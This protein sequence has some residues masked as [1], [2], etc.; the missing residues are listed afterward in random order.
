MQ[1]NDVERYLKESSKSYK[2]AKV[3]NYARRSSL[4]KR[5]LGIETEKKIAAASFN[6]EEKHL[7]EQLKQMKIEKKKYSII[8]DLRDREH[9][10]SAVPEEPRVHE[11]RIPTEPYPITIRPLGSPK[12]ARKNG[13]SFEEEGMRYARNRGRRISKEFE[14]LHINTKTGQLNNKPMNMAKKVMKDKLSGGMTRS[15]TTL[16]PTSP[17]TPRKRSLSRKHSQNSDG[18]SPSHSVSSMDNIHW[19]GELEATKSIRR[20]RKTVEEQELITE[21]NRLSKH[22]PS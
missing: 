18:S 13:R 21:Y 5:T 15:L 8:N 1:D 17:S 14:D 22:S 7:R 10:Q 12:T 19:I 4:Q 2:E 9:S 11:I 6:R 3:K 20:N 16:P